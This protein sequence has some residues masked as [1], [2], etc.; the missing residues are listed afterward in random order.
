M[1]KLTKG[2]K[3]TASFIMSA[4]ISMS[5][6]S[7]AV[8]LQASAVSY[9]EMS[10]LDAQAYSGNDLGAVYS[11]SSTTFKVWAPTAESVKIKR[12]TTGSD[13]ESGASVIETKPM[14]KGSNG[15]W[16]I[17]IS[18]DLKNT[19]YTYL[20]KCGGVEKETNDIYARTTGVN[21]MRA[22]VVDLDSTDPAGWSNDHRV[23]CTNQTDAIIWEVH[24]KDFSSSSD[25]GMTNKGKFLAFTETGTTV[26]NDGVHPT[27]IDYLADLGV[28]HV[29]LLPVYDYDGEIDETNLSANKFNWGYDPVNYNTPEGSY[30]T[31]PYHGEVRIKEFKQMVQAL[32]NKGIGVI[33]DVVYNHTYGKNDWFDFTVPDYYYRQNSQ[34]KQSNGSGCG[35]ETASDR[36]MFRKYMID[37][38]TYWA[39]EY[40]LDGF[41]FDLM[42]LHD[43]ET[44]NQIRTAL[45]AIDPEILMYGEPWWAEETT[46]PTPTAVQGNI[47]KLN[48]D[49]A[50]FNDKVRDAIKGSC[51]GA[52]APGFI[53]GAGYEEALKAGI[54]ANSTDLAGNDKWSL[55]PSQTVT[56]TSAHDNYTLYDKL[57]SS[58]KGGSGFGNRY[59]DLVAMNKIAGGIILTSQGM[60]FFQAG[61]EFARSKNGDENSYKSP[62]SIN[63][64]VWSRTTTYSDL[65]AYYKGLIQIRKAYSPF[66]TPTNST[67]STIY[68]SW[69]TSCPSNVVAFTM[70]NT[71]APESEWNY[72]GVIHNSASYAQQ[73]TLMSSKTLPSQWT[74]IADGST[75]G[76]QSLGTTGSTV[77][78]PARSTMVL[79]DKASFDSTVISSGG[80]VTVNH[81]IKPAGTTYK[82]ET[83]KGKEGASYSTSPLSELLSQGYKVDSTSG[84]T[85]GTYT[86][87]GTTVTYYYTIDSSKFAQI[88]VKYQDAET[89]KSIADDA[90]TSGEIGKTYSV[91]PKQINGYECD[92]SLTGNATG[93]LPA[94]GVTVIFKYNE[95][96]PTGLKI[97]YYNSSGWSNVGMYVYTGKGSTAT[98][99]TGAWPGTAMTN[100][101]NGW[102]VGTVNF[103][104][105]ALFIANNNVA[106]NA[107]QDPAGINPDGYSVTGE[108]WI[109]GGKVYP[110]GKVTVKYQ[111]QDGVILDKMTLTG[112]ADGTATYTTSAK[113][114][115]GY[116]LVTS[117]TN[118]SGPYT[119]AEITVTYVYKSKSAPALS[120]SSTISPAKITLGS[121]A[122][123]TC[124]AS[125]GT[126]PYTYA[127]Y[128]K[129]SSA[130]YY[131]T[132]RDYASGTSVKVTPTEPGTYN[133]RVRAKDKNGTT[134]DKTLTLTV[135]DSG[136]TL[137][138]K[139]TLSSTT[140]TVGGT[141]TVT[142]TGSGGTSPYTY[143]VYYKLSTSTYYTAV[144]DY[145]TTRTVKVTTAKEGTYN[146]RVRVKDSK[147]NMANKDFNVTVSGAAL[148]NKSTISSTTSNAGG[149]V[150]VTAT[151]SGGTSPYTYAVYYK[152]STST[153]YTT[154]QD[155]STTRT[156]K[157]TTAKEA[158]YNIRVRVKDKKGTI[159]NKDFT[160]KSSG[161]A[162]ANKSTISATSITAGKS[163]TV[164]GT[165]SGGTSPY[166]YALYY[167]KSSAN[168]Y[169]T[170]KDFSTTRTMSLTLKEA[171]TYNLRTKVKDSKGTIASK[172]FNVTVTAAALA[173]STKLSASSIELGSSVTITGAASGGTS[174]YKYAAYS[175]LSTSEYFS[176]IR[177]FSTTKTITFTPSAAGKYTIRTKVQD[178]DGTIK[179]KDLTLTVTDSL[180]NATTVSSTSITLGDVLTVTCKAT[181]GS[182]GYNYAVYYKKSSSSSYTTAQ[183]FDTNRIVKITPQAATTYNIRTKVKDSA[184]KIVTKDF[185]VKVANA[186]SLVN[187]STVSP[188]KISKG[189]CVIVHANASCGTK[190]Y[191]YAVYYKHS[192]ADYYTTKQS[193]ST[194]NSIDITP[195]LTG[196]YNIRVNVKDNTGKIVTKDLT[197]KVV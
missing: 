57:V 113:T 155:Y 166:Q 146:I 67:N 78:V 96:A 165:A 126:S 163:V 138:N 131:S 40:H 79:V 128:Y 122:T 144:Q 190:P 93:T 95:T 29:H 73:V 38:L 143:A 156:I 63:Q 25:S 124:S 55:Q 90:V 33:M 137:V 77:T 24:V 44:M 120:N 18:G 152:L 176:T 159:A 2:L 19:Y 35:N 94:G 123:V 195:A 154:V 173:N 105:T 150:T 53:Q 147:G 54:Q 111:T 110:T 139:S 49:I 7:V 186:T 91:S 5:V 64:L 188:A 83:L 114:F 193:F 20:V 100:E 8:P 36:A 50:A 71:I 43:C 164:T 184:G 4:L 42:G 102:Y 179:S 141:V 46:C 32:H 75:A 69:G 125:G 172:N 6:F 28:T 115:E 60:S 74:I 31:D 180:S 183:A 151:G 112:I 98:Q 27:G 182:S 130:T 197:I 92:T 76:L 118:A 89:G 160:V 45:D 189:D 107:E 158:T 149:T 65:L 21:G 191:Y 129:L 196:T 178:S 12:Y 81:V 48:T 167:K 34:G 72:V 161:A 109:K 47:K 121:S 106:N 82:T 61:E 59:D 68:F 194:N 170:V 145:S 52:G 103:N 16:S 157:V 37:S 135:E 140:S 136:S 162:L 153:Y 142:A 181:G 39:E 171:G 80:K 177:S 66:R 168:Y 85:T 119:Q 187:L 116:E 97:H 9:S 134:K 117:P 127:V 41:R 11:K 10:A 3:K 132:V 169:S 108:V 1:T 192:S 13:A 84:Q 87:A 14:T 51:F 101:G 104:D 174:P 26:N 62:S 15:V 133:V 58:V 23:G 30:S 56:Y 70:Y 185:T 86:K 99:L 88:T 17:T 148:T 175:K 22:M